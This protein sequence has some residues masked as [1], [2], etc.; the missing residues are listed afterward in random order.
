[1]R[2][3]REILSI[4]ANALLCITAWVFYFKTNLFAY[5]SNTSNHPI[6]MF[7]LWHNDIDKC[8]ML[9]ILIIVALSIWSVATIVRFMLLCLEGKKND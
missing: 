7:D 1:M 9:N 8:K 2:K 3:A 5:L 6:L 4:V